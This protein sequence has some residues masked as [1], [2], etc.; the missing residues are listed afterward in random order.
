[1]QWL[2][3]RTTGY[4]ATAEA[5]AKAGAARLILDRELTGEELF[6]TIRDFAKQPGQLLEM[7]VAAKRFAAPHA[8]KRA[9]E[10]LE[11]EAAGAMGWKAS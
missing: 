1:M 9:L 11:E 5:M 8:A 3:R 4:R 10:I 7:G 6:H 2:W